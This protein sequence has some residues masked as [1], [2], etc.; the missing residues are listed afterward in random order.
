MKVRK[1][2][3][4]ERGLSLLQ[5]L[6][7][8]EKQTDC[9]TTRTLKKAQPESLLAYR[10]KYALMLGQAEK[11]YFFYLKEKPWKVSSGTF[12]WNLTPPLLEYSENTSPSA[13]NR[14]LNDRWRK[15][16]NLLW[17]HLNKDGASM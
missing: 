9:Q 10:D 8:T 7:P 2:E 6:F 3:R 17:I 4:L 15:P 14:F 11:A 5:S 16:T 13:R 12:L 1:A